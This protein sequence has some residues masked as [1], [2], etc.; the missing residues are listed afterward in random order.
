MKPMSVSNFFTKHKKEIVSYGFFLLLSY[1]LT[2]VLLLA[3][4]MAV[5]KLRLSDQMILGLTTA[6][7]IAVTFLAGILIGHKMKR[8]KFFHGAFIGFLYFLI[9]LLVSLF[10]SPEHA[11]DLKKA[12]RIFLLCTAAGML[13]GMLAHP[14]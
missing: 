11:L 1:L 5:Y 4:A 10:L 14:K 8:K 9:L 12:L 3:M 6:V 7:Y 2:F 13:G